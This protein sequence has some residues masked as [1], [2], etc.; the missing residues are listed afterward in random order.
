M[1]DAFANELRAGH[2]GAPGRPGSRSVWAE[3]QAA[4]EEAA[5]TAG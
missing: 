4:Y 2:L 3:L 1:W 5:A